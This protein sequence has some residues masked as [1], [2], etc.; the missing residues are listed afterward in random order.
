MKITQIRQL[1]ANSRHLA[2][3]CGGLAGVLALAALYAAPGDAQAAHNHAKKTGAK[4]TIVLVHGAWA[5][6]SSWSRV[7]RRLQ[8]R[9]YAVV[10]PPNPLRGVTPDSEYL[11]DFLKT[12]TGPVVLV[13]HSYGG[14]VIT[15]GGVGDPNVKALVYVDAYI[16]KEGQSLLG[17]TSAQPGSALG[18]NPASVFNF[19][20]F[21]GAPEGDADLYVKQALFPSAFANGLPAD[22]GAKLAAI[23]RPLAANAL[24]EKSGAP[25]WAT[26][27]SWSVIGTADHVLPPAEQRVMSK[28]AHAQTTEIPAPHL[29]MLS[30]PEAVTAVIVKAAE[31]TQ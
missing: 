28:E 22:E 2:R 24:E 23:Q 8:L 1:T 3:A 7:I 10:A 12:V 29:S 13:G 30:D 20:P 21:P 18:G 26:T 9:G 4:P 16:P 15:N 31:A 19:A 11:A 5:D 14:F 27:P 17:L 6:A 25:A